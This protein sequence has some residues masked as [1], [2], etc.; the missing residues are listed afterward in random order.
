[1]LKLAVRCSILLDQARVIAL[2]VAKLYN[3]PSSRVLVGTAH[4]TTTV[5][6]SSYSRAL[7]GAGHSI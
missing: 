4:P 5:I 6:H 2:L 7:R 3:R 1:M